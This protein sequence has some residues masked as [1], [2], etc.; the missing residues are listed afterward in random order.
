MTAQQDAEAVSFAT[1]F[2][3]K[4][5]RIRGVK[6]DRKTFLSQEFK[7]TGVSEQKIS[8][9]IL[10]T[11]IE[12]G[13]EPKI[14][15]E[16]AAELIAFETKK[17]ASMSFASGLPGGFGMV[18][19]IPAD[20]TQYYV[21]AFRVMQKLAYLY[22]WKEFLNDLDNVDDQTL[23]L[24]ASFL[25]TMMGVAGAAN[26]LTTFAKNIA[27]PAL[28][29]HISKKALTKTVW[30]GPVKQ[31]LKLVGVKITKDSFAKGVT[32]AVPLVGGV[33]SGGLTYVSLKKQANRLQM[34][35]RKN[36]PP[37]RD[38]EKYLQAFSELDKLDEVNLESDESATRSL[39]GRT[40]NAGNSALN[41]AT[42]GILAASTGIGTIASKVWQGKKAD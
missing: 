25:G 41:V 30:Y 5:I 1:E 29:K 2:L 6:I 34:H 7:R 18:A 35:L 17:S 27:R 40:L 39:A 9:A 21:H 10:E 4:I 13:I 36:P 42:K 31:T 23:G 15:D 3:K 11:P 12:A 8:E 26:S 22:G 14:L 16:L 20:I 37:S 24:L 28:Q 32:K 19:A 33:V 38:A